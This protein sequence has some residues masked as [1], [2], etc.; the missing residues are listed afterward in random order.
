M[1]DHKMVVHCW[2]LYISGIGGVY[3]FSNY[4]FELGMCHDG[5]SINCLSVKLVVCICVYVHVYRSCCCCL[6]VDCVC[7]CVNK[8][9]ALVS[10]GFF[11]E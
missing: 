8:L 1:I 3:V 4:S 11:F 10:I 7:V 6:I 5:D 9:L 2:Q